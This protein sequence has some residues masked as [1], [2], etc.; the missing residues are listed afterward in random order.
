M[1]AAVELEGVRYTYPSGFSL[2]GIDLRVARG[3]MVAVVGPNGSGKSTLLKVMLG[4]LRPQ[5]GE[6]RV[7]GRAIGAMTRRDVARVIAMVPQEVSLSS[8]LTAAE[9]V[10]L[11]RT[12]FLRRFGGPGPEDR[13]SVRAA[14]TATDVLSLADRL[15]TELSGGE[16][17]RV[18]LAMA[19]AQEPRLLLLD[20]PTRY[21]DPGH[22]LRILALLR[23]LNRERA[24]TVISAMHDLNLCSLH[25]DRLILLCSGKI[26]AD[27]APESVIR[28][29]LL[30]WVFGVRALIQRHPTHAVPLV[31]L[32]PDPR[33]DPPSHRSD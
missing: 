30:E 16:R 27:G 12:A 1:S 6:L 25:F 15:F 5:A 14:M 19:L 10:L 23:R 11:G 24:L 21:L 22:Q 33:L 2:S 4:L 3:E 7:E 26:A 8:A 13:E 20:E 31:T 32:V 9:V 28:E 18:V 17:Q 29:D